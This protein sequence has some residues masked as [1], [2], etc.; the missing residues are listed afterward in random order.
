MLGQFK[1]GKS[2]IIDAIRSAKCKNGNKDGLTVKGEYSRKSRF[3]GAGVCN[4][5]ASIRITVTYS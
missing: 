2:S 5:A 4:Y 3:I 1:S